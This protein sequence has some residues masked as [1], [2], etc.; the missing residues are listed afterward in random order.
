MERSDREN[1]ASTVA[2]FCE[3]R[4]S[5]GRCTTMLFVVM[6][7]LITFMSIDGMLCLRE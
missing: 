3:E 1:I 5:F 4:R 2:H 6:F 7:E